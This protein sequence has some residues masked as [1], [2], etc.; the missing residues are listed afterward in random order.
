[1]QDSLSWGV[2]QFV[3]AGFQDDS[4]LS[5]MALLPDSRGN[6]AADRGLAA[7]WQKKRKNR[8]TR[9]Q[10]NKKRAGI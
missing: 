9:K 5:I 4:G 2:S 10:E 3:M 7:A 8:K 1:M 6:R